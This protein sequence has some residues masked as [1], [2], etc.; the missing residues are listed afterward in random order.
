MNL[1]KRMFI[2]PLCCDKRRKCNILDYI[3]I[4]STEK[5]LIWEEE[6][7]PDKS[8]KLRIQCK[9]CLTIFETDWEENWYSLV[10][11]PSGQELIDLIS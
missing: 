3:L 11:L 1:K 5:G 6:T 7:I 2:C 8:N 9:T 10:K 4:Q